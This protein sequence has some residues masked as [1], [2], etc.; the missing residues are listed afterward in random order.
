MGASLKLVG[1]G[2]GAMVGISYT[3]G[4]KIPGHDMRVPSQSIVDMRGSLQRKRRI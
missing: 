4:G 3:H 2:V 1:N